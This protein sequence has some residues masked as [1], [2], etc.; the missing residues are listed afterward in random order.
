MREYRQVIAQQ[1]ARELRTIALF[2]II[3]V[4]CVGT[5]LSAYIRFRSAPEA[6]P[7]L[8]S[9]SVLVELSPTRR[10]T[11]VTP[12]PLPTSTPTPTETPL[13]TATPTVV[14]SPTPTPPLDP[15]NDMITYDT[16]DPVGEAPTGV[17][18]RTANALGIREGVLVYP[19]H[20]QAT[21]GTLI[22][23]GPGDVCLRYLVLDLHVGLMVLERRGQRLT[24]QIA[25]M[26]DLGTLLP[27]AMGG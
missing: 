13:P 9:T 2:I 27:V 21:S 4:L 10:A 1:R 8:T 23:R 7:T 22:I 20:D 25:E 6:S 3:L 19:A 14:P 12:S 24:E 17:D 11:L 5:G 26:L 15:Q 18:I 16:G